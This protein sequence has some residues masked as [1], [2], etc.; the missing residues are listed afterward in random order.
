MVPNA[1]A[2]CSLNK[3]ALPTIVYQD[4]DEGVRVVISSQGEGHPLRMDLEVL[5]GVDR[6]GGWR[7]E[8]LDVKGDIYVALHGMAVSLLQMRDNA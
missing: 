3:A 2:R 5:R 6:M 7:W 4:N 8:D 1:N